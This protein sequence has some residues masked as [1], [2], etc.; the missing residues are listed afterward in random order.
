MTVR[1]WLS[2][3]AREREEEILATTSGQPGDQIR[4]TIDGLISDNR[5]IH[6]RECLNLNPATNVLSP[7]A[8]AALAKGLGNRPSLG[9]PGEKYEVG[10]EAIESLEVI[11]AD[12]AQQV[13]GCGIAEIRVFSGAMANLTAFMACAEPGDSI[14][15]PPPTIGGHVT[16]NTD[17]AAG[18]YGL[19]IH[20]APIDPERYTVD[21]AGVAELAERV[22][23]KV[24]TIGSSMNLQPHPVAELREIADAVGATLLFDA[25]HLCGLFAG[26]AWPNPLHEGAHV[27]T[28]STYKSLGGPAGGLVLSDDADLMARVDAIAYPGLTANFDAGR[29]TALAYTLLDWLEHG[30]AY[31]AEMVASAAA[32]SVALED[33]GVELQR[34]AGAGTT[35]HQLAIRPDGIDADE[36]VRRLRTANLLTCAIGLPDGAGVRLGTPEAVRWGMTSSDM[37]ILAGCIDEGLREVAGVG[38]RVTEWRAPFATVQFCS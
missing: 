36:A 33:R 4:S 28:M 16:H 25:A 20:E 27:M 22:R 11:T 13:F 21:V 7:R 17:G 5:R 19:D 23:P 15:V 18:L 29:T 35:S 2:A 24:I 1:P 38:E 26:R 10:L 30:E 37:D 31:A 9:H 12:L 6:E 32:L 34:A 14:I 3:P 8:E